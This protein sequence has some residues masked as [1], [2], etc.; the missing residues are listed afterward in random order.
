[1]WHSLDIESVRH[2]SLDSGAVDLA[3][4]DLFVGVSVAEGGK[5]RLEMFA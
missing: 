2:V 3:E 4:N 1:V 5:L